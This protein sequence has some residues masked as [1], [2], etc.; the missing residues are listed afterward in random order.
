MATSLRRGILVLQALNSDEAIAGAGLGVLRLAEL[1]GDDKSQISRTLKALHQ[2]GLVDRDPDTRAYRLGWAL[3][4]LAARAGDTRLLAAG[5]REL[6]DLVH[7]LGERVHLNVLQGAEVLTVLSESPPRAL[8]AVDWV[9]RTVPTY[10]SSAGQA[11]LTDWSREDVAELLADTDFA[12]LGPSSPKTIVEFYARIETAR[13][14]GYALVDEEFEPGLVAAAAPVRDFRGH[15]VA[16][17]NASGPKFR[18]G[19]HLDEVG[20]EVA[21]AADR[22]SAALGHAVEG[23]ASVLD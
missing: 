5:E 7:T 13:A 8:Q 2:Y 16:A 9:G 20:R 14:R 17:L 22:L 15:V 18:L 6:K 4:T 21:A 10:C 11:L 3:F 19:P 23:A 12:P 1:V